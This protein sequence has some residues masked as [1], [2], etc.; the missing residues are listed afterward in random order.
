MPVDPLSPR[1]RGIRRAAK[2]MFLSGA[3]LPVFI[4]LCILVEDGG[5]LLIPFAVFFIALMWM[6]YARLFG[7]KTA[8]VNTQAAQTSVL[9]SVSARASLPPA[10]N[11]PAPG[12]GQQRVR[13]N[14]LAQP[15]SVTENTTRL[16]D[17][18]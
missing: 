6:L 16:L 8:H 9:G 3:L 1:R 15:P 14:E 10:V 2:L 7:D 17:D 4:I 18:E 5:P 13:T 11:L 12:I